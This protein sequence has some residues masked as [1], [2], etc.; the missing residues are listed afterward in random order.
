MFDDVTLTV[1]VDIVKR[2]KN[3]ANNFEIQESL[4]ISAEK[5]LQFVEFQGTSVPT[6][7]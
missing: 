6:L 5:S 2:L 3:I 7:Y 4:K 1:G